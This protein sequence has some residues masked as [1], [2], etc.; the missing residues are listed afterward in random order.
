MVDINLVGDKMVDKRIV[1]YVL[2]NYHL[3]S[4]RDKLMDN[5][6]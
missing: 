2:I 6:I 5:K 1:I 3:E 4:D